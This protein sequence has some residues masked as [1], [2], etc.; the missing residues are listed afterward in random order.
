[1]YRFLLIFFLIFSTSFVAFSQ[2]IGVTTK[3]NGKKFLLPY[4][5]SAG[6]ETNFNNKDFMTGLS[7]GVQELRFDMGLYLGYYQRIVAKDVLIDKNDGFIY[8]Y[9]EKRSVVFVGIEKRLGYEVNLSKIGIYGGAK[10]LYSYEKYVPSDINV[11]NKFL[12]TPYIGLYWMNYDVELKLNY[13]YADFETSGISKHRIN[14]S[15]LY[16]IHIIDV[17]MF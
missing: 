5:I 4:V 6:L 9:K 14:F 12:F 7:L 10:E 15:F 3:E 11:G 17:P 2:E 13:E 8:K 1:M 16:F